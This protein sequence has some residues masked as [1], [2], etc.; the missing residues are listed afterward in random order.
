MR[1]FPV[2]LAL[3]A[4]VGCKQRNP[5]S[6]G[7][8]DAPDAA[9]GDDD[10]EGL[11]EGGAPVPGDFRIVC[12]PSEGAAARDEYSLDVRGAVRPEDEAQKIRVTVDR[13][14]ATSSQQIDRLAT[15]QRGNGTV[16][17]RGT[18]SLGFGSGALTAEYVGGEHEGILTLAEDAEAKALAVKCGVVAL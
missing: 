7:L 3:A 5:D 2:L 4:A 14:R 9:G 18:I 17:V 8:L 6:A 16:R 13:K 15:Q 10:A 11:A 1:L 12:R